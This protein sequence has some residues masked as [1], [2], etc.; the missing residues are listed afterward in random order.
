MYREVPE[1][2]LLSIKVIPGARQSIIDGVK[3]DELVVRVQAPPDKGAANK[4]V[5]ELLSR[6]LGV[7]KSRIELVRGATNRHKLFC[8]RD[9]SSQELHNIF[10]H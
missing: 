1:G 10:P 5:V 9:Y 8:I 7:S 4:A 3:N 2:I 6:A